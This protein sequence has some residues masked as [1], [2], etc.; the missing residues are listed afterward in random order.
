MIQ[1]YYDYRTTFTLPVGS[2]AVTGLWATD[3]AGVDILVNGHS[4][5]NKIGTTSGS[6]RRLQSLHAFHPEQRLH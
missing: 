3:N 6:L 5:G 4:S 2:N 1:G